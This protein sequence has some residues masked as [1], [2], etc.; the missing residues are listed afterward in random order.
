MQAS[1]DSCQ[2]YE[3][4]LDPELRPLQKSEFLVSYGYTHIIRPWAIERFPR[5][6][7]NLH[8]SLLPWNRGAD[9][10]LWSFLDSTPKGVTIHMVDPGIDTGPIL[11]QRKVTMAEDDTLRSSYHRLSGAVEALFEE[12]WTDIRSGQVTPRPQPQEGTL[13]RLRDRETVSHLLS[14][15]WDTPVRQLIGQETGK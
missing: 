7:I 12:H 3:G 15:G 14:E 2:R 1:G 6:I 4:P 11:F 10:N 8:I 13:H 9:P 5:R